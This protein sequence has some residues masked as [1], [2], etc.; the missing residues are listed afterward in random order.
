[1]SRSHLCAE[2]KRDSAQPQL[3]ER[4][5]W[6]VQLSIIGGFNEPPRL[7]PLRKLRAISLVGVS[8]P[9]LP[10]R[11]LRPPATFGNTLGEEGWLR[12]QNN[13]GEAH[14]R[15]AADVVGYKPCFKNRPPI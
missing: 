4:T 3:M 6:L 9:P 11:G 2:R 10:G 7:R 5:G 15:A 1:M 13:F 14:L 12:H 8:S